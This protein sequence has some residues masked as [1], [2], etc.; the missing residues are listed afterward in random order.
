MGIGEGHGVSGEIANILWCI[1]NHVA[2]MQNSHENIQKAKS[3][4]LK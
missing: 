2:V 3:A 4:V 1:M